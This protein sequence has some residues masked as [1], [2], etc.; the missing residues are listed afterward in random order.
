MPLRTR[1]LVRPAV[2]ACIAAAL[3]LSTGAAAG[4]PPPD[5][6]DPVGHAEGADL[7]DGFHADP[8][9]VYFN[10]LYH[11]YPTTDSNP[12]RNG[13]FVVWTSPDLVNWTDRGE[14]LRLG[15]DVSWADRNAWA[16]DVVERNG[17]YYLYFTAE[18]KI[19]VA[20]ADH[21]GGPFTDLGRPLIAEN[22]GGVGVPID[23]AVFVD[24]DG[25]PYLYWGNGQA[26]VV[27]LNPDMTSF[28]PARITVIGGLEGFG[29][30]M[31]VAK[32]DGTYHLTW[33]IG[34]FRS[35]DY[36]V[37]YA[38]APS[39]SG[40][41]TNRG[42]LLSRDDELGIRGTGHGSVLRIPT[43]DDW[44]YAYHRHA[45]D[46]GD[47]YHREVTIDPLPITPDGLFG[48]ITPTLEGPAP[49]PVPSRP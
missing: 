19:G 15:P 43:T 35:P 25:T 26:H 44:Y 28:D 12:A 45:V 47:G 14:V 34:D 4:G 31:D 10:G 27:P 32:R 11:I 20:V 29:E 42:L 37:A 6:P 33:S 48:R 36:R 23:P 46:G 18:E 7:L 49:R 17:R 38:T 16:P 8:T 3:V 30:G 1:S 13:S 2:T 24:D 40:P 9:I 39:P 5:P 21:P 41:F 22:P